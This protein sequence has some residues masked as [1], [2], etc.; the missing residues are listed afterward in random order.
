MLMGLR[1]ISDNIIYFEST[2][3]QSSASS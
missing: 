3:K 2:D 1:V